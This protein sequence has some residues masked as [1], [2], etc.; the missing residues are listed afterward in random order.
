MSKRQET[1]IKKNAFVHKLYS[2]LN[3]PE[4]VDLIWWTREEDSNTFA[5]SPG[6]DF[7]NA[8]TRYFKHGNVASFVRQLHMYGFHKVSDPSHA[9][10][11]NNDSELPVWEFKHSSGKFKKNDESSLV[12]IKR[13]SSSNNARN[14]YNN[15][16]DANVVIPTSTPS[17]EHAQYLQEGHHYLPQGY[18]FYNGHQVTHHMSPQLPF[19]PGGAPVP[20]HQTKQ[21]PMYY[22][23]KP[24]PSSVPHEYAQ[25][26]A[27]EKPKMQDIQ[28]SIS[29]QSQ[30][31]PQHQVPQ[32]PKPL[33]MA[34]IQPPMSQAQAQPSLQDTTK[35]PYSQP[36]SQDTQQPQHNTPNLQFRKIWENDNLH[37]RP[38][39][40]SLLFD[41]LVPVPVTSQLQPLHQLQNTEQ[42]PQ[43]S[44]S[45]LLPRSD[46]RS[47]YASARES[48]TSTRDSFASNRDSIASGRESLA[49]AKDSFSSARDS[50][51]S[52]R[53]SFGNSRDSFTLSK[54]SDR[55][56]IKL[57][58]PSSIHNPTF[59]TN[60]SNSPFSS[61]SDSNS[62]ASTITT[63]NLP[64]APSKD[65]PLSSTSTSTIKVKSNSIPETSTTA[66]RPSIFPSHSVHEKLR[67]SLIELHF[68]TSNKTSI[69]NPQHDSIGSQSS[70]N[71][72]FSNNSSLSSTSSFHRTSS[73]GSIS[74]HPIF[75]N[76][77]SISIAPHEVL[78]ISL[79]SRSKGSNLE[80]GINP[81]SK[82]ST[83]ALNSPKVPQLNSPIKRSSTTAIPT[84]NGGAVALKIR[85]LNSS[86]L[87]R[88]LTNED[89]IAG[90]SSNT[91]A[92]NTKVSIHSLLEDDHGDEK[93]LL[94][95]KSNIKAGLREVKEVITELNE[96][97]DANED[98]EVK[99]TQRHSNDS[100]IPHNSIQHSK[101][102]V[103]L[104]RQKLD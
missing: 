73:F 48:I 36:D 84:T 5:L 7:A 23:Q 83:P 18:Y 92:F 86:P 58:P 103:D 9:S 11:A 94:P 38:R 63:S 93:I 32:L 64:K 56:S 40:P 68:G 72:V 104:K 96:D 97:K 80:E 98:D 43:S 79:L 75:S 12:Y 33:P 34:H 44:F 47:S 91:R 78:P 26:N 15:E 19:P 62:Q 60:N 87:S 50:F 82:D 81:D 51:G 74:H 16:N 17:P 3:D 14:V 46:S 10:A 8:L 42:Q 70:H 61:V 57:P 28:R 76:K 41:P 52:A 20:L 31:A 100:Q 39:N 95:S 2:M 35:P 54:D 55:L 37:S 99:D 4:L 59:Y 77:N 24:M 66:K 25:D 21:P 85:S 27:L 89:L 22:T 65:S 29:P 53:D 6:K 90:E 88:L 67:P 13:R 30:P 71:S 1:P 49:S 69:L 45:Y 101:S 102:L